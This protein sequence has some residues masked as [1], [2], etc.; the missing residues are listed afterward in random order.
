MSNKQRTSLHISHILSHGCD[1]CE[2]LQSK[3][4]GGGGGG[5]VH[6]SFWE[7][8]AKMAKFSFSKTIFE[9]FW[10]MEK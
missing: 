9:S 6:E 2:C 10:E 3:G 1:N 4:G 7:F 5:G 8:P